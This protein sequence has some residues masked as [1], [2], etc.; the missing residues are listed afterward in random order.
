[1]NVEMLDTTE[2]VFPTPQPGGVT[3]PVE[4]SAR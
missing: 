2:P 1:M 4:V 3:T